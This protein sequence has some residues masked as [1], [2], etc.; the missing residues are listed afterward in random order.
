M[1]LERIWMANRSVLNLTFPSPEW[2]S[3]KFR[4]QGLDDDSLKLCRHFY[5]SDV[6]YPLTDDLIWDCTIFQHDNERDLSLTV[7]SGERKGGT[8]YF[9]APESRRIDPLETKLQDWK[10]FFFLHMDHVG[11]SQYLPVTVQLAPFKDVSYNISL[12]HCVNNDHHCLESTTLTN[13]LISDPQKSADCEGDQC[14]VYLLLW[15]NPGRYAVTAQI[16]SQEC[17]NNGCFTSISPTF[18]VE[19]SQVGIWITVAFAFGL[20]FVLT[21]ALTLHRR[22]R[23]NKNLLLGLKEKQPTVLLIYLAENQ[24]CWDLVN[25]LAV[26]LNEVCYVYPY[27]IDNDVGSQDP[28]FWTSERM[29]QVDRLVFLVPGDPDSES[30]TPIRDHWTYALKYFTGH[31]FATHQV[32]DKVATVIFPFSADVPSQIANVQRFKLVKDMDL[33]VTWIHR[34]TWLDCKFLWE[35][36]IKSPCQKEV[37]Y[38]LSDITKTVNNVVIEKLYCIYKMK[39]NLNEKNATNDLV[40]K[41]YASQTASTVHDKCSERQNSYT[42]SEV[43]CDSS[44]E[45][46]DPEVPN[47]E[48]LS[49]LGEKTNR[50]PDEQSSNESSDE[51][52]DSIFL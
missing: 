40:E 33:L 26:F 29:N 46:F 6:N 2:T 8:Y 22:I 19:P 5:L 7:V 52:D 36:Q 20:I 35:P 18:S 38:T 13:I 31:Y 11:R 45:V 41:L 39:R 47:I 42:A 28:N 32:T 15:A 9:N 10:V 4:Y 49:L 14:I 37:T 23:Q 16:V 17:P 44:V 51:P 3:L 24:R 1:Y 43:A 50:S 27:V 21:F 48:Q 25:M 34:G 12:V 30:V